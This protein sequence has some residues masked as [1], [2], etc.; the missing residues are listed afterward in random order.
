MDEKQ[1]FQIMKPNVI[2]KIPFNQIIDREFH[3]FFPSLSRSLSLAISLHLS[4]K[5][6]GQNMETNDIYIIY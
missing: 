2:M 1:E 6:D 4:T 3:H 5:W